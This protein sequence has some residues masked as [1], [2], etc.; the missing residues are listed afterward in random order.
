MSDCT[1]Q[2]IDKDNEASPRSLRIGIAVSP[3]HLPLSVDVASAQPTRSDTSELS[4]ARFRLLSGKNW[5]N[6]AL[7]DELKRSSRSWS[8]LRS[9]N[10]TVQCFLGIWFYLGARSLHYGCCDVPIQEIATK[11]KEQLKEL[12]DLEGQV[13]RARLTLKISCKKL[14]RSP[15]Q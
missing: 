9:S 15:R 3:F 12:G 5:I 7:N 11:V 8:H 1:N 4:I 6:C 10:N 14:K 13:A 2:L